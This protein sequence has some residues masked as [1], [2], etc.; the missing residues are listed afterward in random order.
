MKH[1]GRPLLCSQEPFTG[2]Y[3]EPDES[4]PSVRPI[5]AVQ[6]IVCFYGSQTLLAMFTKAYKWTLFF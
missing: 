1:E 6:E 2:P 5:S 3:L 4:S